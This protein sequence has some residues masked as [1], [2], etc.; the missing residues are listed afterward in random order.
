[1]A[2]VQEAF[3]D[4]TSLPRGS[5]QAPLVQPSQP[6][7]TVRDDVTPPVSAC[8]KHGVSMET[9]LP[10]HL[11]TRWLV[12]IRRRRRILHHCPSAHVHD[13]CQGRVNC[14]ELCCAVLCCSMLYLVLS[15][16]FNILHIPE[17]DGG[18]DEQR[19]TPSQRHQR[20][21]PVVI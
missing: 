3:T 19:D 5:V 21:L 17:G 7:R 13:G 14:T 20:Q 10:C 2:R 12:C 15:C 4:Q 1:M 9:M 11:K 6:A 8:C 16:S 18:C